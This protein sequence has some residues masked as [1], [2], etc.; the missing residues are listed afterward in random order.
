MESV[1]K[2][3]RQ[4]VDFYLKLDKNRQICDV[5][6]RIGTLFTSLQGR[7]LL[8]D[9]VYNTIERELSKLSSDE[10]Q[11]LKEENVQRIII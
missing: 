10:I 2:T 11:K 1:I 3:I 8:M 4:G 9:I 6:P 5:K 7:P